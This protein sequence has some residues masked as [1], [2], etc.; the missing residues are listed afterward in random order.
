MIAK[1]LIPMRAA[2][3]RDWCVDDNVVLFTE[4]EHCGLVRGNAESRHMRPAWRGA[5]PSR[6][7]TM[8][9]DLATHVEKEN[10]RRPR[11]S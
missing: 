2:A 5:V 11:S 6:S 10:V 1:N 9:G 4:T 8:A 7:C 3:H